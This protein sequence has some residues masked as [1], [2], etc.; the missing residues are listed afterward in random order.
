MIFVNATAFSQNQPANTGSMI[1]FKTTKILPGNSSYLIK[2]NNT[3]PRFNSP[4]ITPDFYVTRLGFFCKKEIKFEKATK[5]PLRFRLGS[6]EDCDRMEGKSH[7]Q[8]KN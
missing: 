7:L 6:V 8:I 4:F 2:T 1:L 5:I 3:F